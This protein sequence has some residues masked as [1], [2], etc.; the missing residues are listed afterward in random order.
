MAQSYTSQSVNTIVLIFRY[1]IPVHRIYPHR[2]F[3]GYHLAEIVELEVINTE[4]TRFP[5]SVLCAVVLEVACTNTDIDVTF[6]SD[7]EINKHILQGTIIGRS[8]MTC[9]GI[10][11]TLC[12]DT[13][14][15]VTFTAKI[16]NILSCKEAQCA[17]T[18]F[19]A[20]QSAGQTIATWLQ[21]AN[22]FVEL[23]IR[24]HRFIPEPT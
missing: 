16:L 22:G 10:A 19:F 20:S 21:I 4:S 7:L 9:K 17:K 13:G 24:R 2:C 14:N 5:R 6:L 23:E 11:F 12:K 3:V 1:P 8:C 18:V 15:I